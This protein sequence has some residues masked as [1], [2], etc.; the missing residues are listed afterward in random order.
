[1]AKIFSLFGEI[2]VENEKANTAITKTTEKASES[3]GGF[4]KMIGAAGKVGAAVLA[5]TT[6][7]VGGM[8]AMVTKVTETTGAIKDNADKAGTSAENYQKWKFAAEQSGMSMESLQTAMVKQQKMF[9][10]AKTGSEKSGEAYKALGIDIKKVGS[11]SDAFDQVVTKLANMKDETARNALATKIFGKSYAE[12]GPLLDSGGQGIAD[13][14]QK[15]S[16]LGMVMSNETVAAGENLGDT[17]DQVKGAAMGIFNSLGTSLIPTVQTFADM[18]IANMPQIQ[19]MFAQIGPALTTFFAQALPMMMHLVSTLLPVI[20]SL[21]QQLLPVIMQLL[22][23][24]MQIIQ[25]ILPVIMQLLKTLLPPIMQIV[26][27]LLP[28]LLA[29]ISPILPLMQPIL[30]LL[31]PLINLLL[32]I[33]TPL[34]NILNQILPPLATMLTNYFQVML[35]KLTVAFDAVGKIIGGAVTTAFNNLKP[36][37]EGLKKVFSGI[38]DFVSGVFSGDWKKSW[39]GI[40]TIF[41]GIWGSLSGLVKAPLNTMIDMLN[42]AFSAIGTITIPEWVP[43]LGGKSFSL[44]HIPRL[45]VGLDYVPYDEFP[46][47]LHKGERVMTAKDNEQFSGGK[48]GGATINFY[49]NYNFRDKN[50]IDY[51]MN[52]MELAVRRA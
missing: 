35:P 42:R 45:A 2:F 7:A 24:F 44:P 11:S 51:F 3:E 18:I 5:G 32:Q 19:A 43:G 21:I 25:S 1:M 38:T 26:Q 13:L 33:I 14:K 48:S 41:T 15:A 23:V 17:L 9:S 29:L 40:K 34:V 31:T 8:A 37:I 12:L 49:G 27:M 46:A 10:D 36:V 4:G 6:V 20:L 50:D 28:L 30:S 39:D 52:Q 22:P 16:D 47:L